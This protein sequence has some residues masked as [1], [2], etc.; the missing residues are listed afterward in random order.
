MVFTE[1]HNYSDLETWHAISKRPRYSHQ[2]HHR[3]K[4]TQTGLYA[5]ENDCRTYYECAKIE[6]E[7]RFEFHQIVH[8]CNSDK[9]F[10]YAYGT[11]IQPQKSERVKCNGYSR[12]K[13]AAEEQHNTG[14]RFN[15]N[16]VYS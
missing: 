10:S 15:N 1:T 5:D 7:H 14:N 11:C 12:F 6:N 16:S 3:F 13:R 8:K 4:C 2:S 9:V